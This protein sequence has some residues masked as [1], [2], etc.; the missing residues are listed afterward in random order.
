VQHIC[1]LLEEAQSRNKHLLSSNHSPEE[2]EE[3]EEEEEAII[4]KEAI[5][6]M[7]GTEEAELTRNLREEAER[8]ALL[9]VAFQIRIDRL[10]EEEKTMAEGELEEE[11]ED[12]I[13]KG[14]VMGISISNSNSSSNFAHRNV[15]QL[16]AQA[17]DQHWCH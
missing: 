3:E 16:E 5:I 6:S 7:V 17:K 11:G 4:S 2:E 9:L 1:H 10:G 12:L 13:I 14:E 8:L 15:L